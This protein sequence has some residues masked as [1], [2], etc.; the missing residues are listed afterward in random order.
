MMAEPGQDED[1]TTF[2][3]VLAVFISEFHPV[4]G[5]KV[6]YE[7]PDGWF[8][9]MTAKSQ[10]LEGLNISLDGSTLA[11]RTEEGGS[12]DERAKRTSAWQCALDDNS[13]PPR[14]AKLD[15]DA[16]SEYIIP[17]PELCNSLVTVLVA[18]V[19][20]VYGRESLFSVSGRMEIIKSWA[21]RSASRMQSISGMRSCSIWV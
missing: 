20:L 13:A 8:L 16:I 15:F 1:Q 21:F 6:V 18:Y 12:M 19:L 9:P 2:P 14:V 7:V 11:E 17:K 4:Q 5:P 3:K 10:V